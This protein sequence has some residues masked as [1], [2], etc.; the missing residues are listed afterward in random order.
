M[1]LTRKQKEDIFS[2]VSDKLKKQK[3]LAFT[4]FHGLSVANMSELKRKMKKAGA[5]YKVV[6]KNILA[7][8]IEKSD[9]KDFDAKKLE[10]SVG[11]TFSYEDEVAPVKALY[12]FVKEKNLEGFKIVGGVLENKFLTSNEVVALA[13][14][15]SKQELLAKLVSQMNAPIS[16]FVNA[17]AG[18]IKNLAYVLNAIKEKKA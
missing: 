3:S 14:L 16:G 9:I 1:A 12:D 6:K 15:P 13:K 7:K 5:E 11:V 4:D 18:N 2:L 8:A 17:L 10:G